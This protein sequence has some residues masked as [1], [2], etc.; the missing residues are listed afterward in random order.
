MYD[1]IKAF[2]SGRE[3]GKADK[4]KK[5]KKLTKLKQMIVREREQREVQAL[6]E[7]MV[8]AVVMHCEGRGMS[9]SRHESVRE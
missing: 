6:L 5:K 7:D 8:G 9:P 4:P 1:R 2:K 3:R